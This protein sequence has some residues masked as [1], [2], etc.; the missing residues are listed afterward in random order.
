MNP[1][2]YL[3][4]IIEIEHFNEYFDNTVVKIILSLSPS[5]LRRLKTLPG[6]L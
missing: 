4:L 1:N 2:P 6:K 5:Y 3:H